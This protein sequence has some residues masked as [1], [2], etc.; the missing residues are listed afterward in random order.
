MISVFA[1][2]AEDIYQQ[3]ARSFVSAYQSREEVQ[4]ASGPSIQISPPT[5]DEEISEKDNLS[6]A[7]ET[8]LAVRRFIGNYQAHMFWLVLYHLVV[9][10]IFAERA[11]CKCTW[12]S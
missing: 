4:E 5:G 9:F 7:Y 10:A 11:Y 1:M 3:Q 8:W 12:L 2:R 6:R